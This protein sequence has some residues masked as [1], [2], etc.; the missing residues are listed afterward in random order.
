[1]TTNDVAR[2]ATNPYGNGGPPATPVKEAQ[3]GPLG[4]YFS[5]EFP[6]LGAVTAIC[7]NM[8]ERKL[9]WESSPYDM[10]APV[11]FCKERYKL[12]EAYARLLLAPEA[13]SIRPCK[14]NDE[15]VAQ[16]VEAIKAELLGRQ[17][18]QTRKEGEP[19]DP[20]LASRYPIVAE[21]YEAYELGIGEPPTNWENT[22]MIELVRNRNNSEDAVW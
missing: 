5:S 18:S 16:V 11:K 6:F 1:M 3:A 2:Q 19:F 12:S 17:P 9:I 15:E 8:T 10:S 4:P 21:L 7:C 20:V 14:P 13:S 22:L